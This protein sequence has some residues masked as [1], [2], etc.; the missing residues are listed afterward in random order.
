MKERIFQ[1]CHKEVPYGLDNDE[2][3]TPLEVGYITRGTHVNGALSDATGNNISELNPCFAETTG[4]YWVWRNHDTD[5]DY[6]GVEQYRR[7][8]PFN[9]GV[10]FDALLGNDT[11]V[12]CKPL[13]FSRGSVKGQFCLFH[14]NTLWEFFKQAVDVTCPQYS[15]AFRNYLENP[16]PDGK[17]AYL[18]YSNGFVAPTKI[19]DAYC[20]EL[21]PV[22]EYV[23]SA[24]GGTCPKV[25][26]FVEKE[27]KE[28]RWNQVSNHGKG[29][30]ECVR[31]Q[32]QVCGFVSE[33]FF[34]LWLRKNYGDKIIEVPYVL[35][36][37]SVI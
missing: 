9:S 35:K 22:L 13:Q 27:I 5:L 19:F 25:Y 16:T 18:Y 31:Y 11:V 15:E 10:N 30:E 34:T 20:S 29:L 4:L 7:R 33:R 6:I 28:G 23:F 21:F 36:E 1:F 37:N 2:L 14:S 12:A 3:H 24:L 26:A 32:S 8:L 17:P